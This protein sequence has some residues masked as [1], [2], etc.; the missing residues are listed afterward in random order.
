MAVW[1]SC[2]ASDGGGDAAR[3]P[4]ETW[5]AA[6][7]LLA[8]YTLK[9]LSVAFPL[10]V[11]EAAGGLLFPFPL[12]LAVNLAGD[13]GAAAPIFWAGGRQESSL[14]EHWGRGFSQPPRTNAVLLLRLAGVLQ[15]IWSAS[16]L[17]PPASPWGAYLTGGCWEAFPGCLPLRCGKRRAVGVR[18]PGLLPLCSPAAALTLLSLVLWRAWPRGWNR[19]GQ[20]AALHSPSRRA[21]PL[22]RRGALA[23]SGLWRKIKG[24]S[25]GCRPGS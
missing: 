24:T 4:R 2:G 19:P 23:V 21:Q 25:F 17:A 13:G 22:H 6:L 15:A 9:G 5:L 16:H 1:P 7:F 20:A 18:L 12:A 11:L 10:S 3:L 8:L 14:P